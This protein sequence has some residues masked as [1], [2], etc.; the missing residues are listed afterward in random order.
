[1][2]K[3]SDFIEDVRDFALIV[4]AAPT[5]LKT[6]GAFT[7]GIASTIANPKAAQ[8]VYKGGTLLRVGGQ[9]LGKVL[10]A[11]TT[12]VVRASTPVVKSVAKS[13]PFS[14]V[15]AP[16]IKYVPV[17]AIATASTILG[18]KAVKT[19]KQISNIKSSPIAKLQSDRT[20]FDILNPASWLN[21]VK[22][23]VAFK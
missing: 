15:I 19:A 4:A 10:K 22:E 5:A 12:A 1:M 18:A 16:Y 9:A 13:L 3:I 14:K 6:A 7:Q 11:G 20:K 21:L 17:A 2:G 23:A 8:V